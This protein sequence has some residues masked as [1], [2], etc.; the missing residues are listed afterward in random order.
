ML[1]LSLH[2]SLYR[3]KQ[4]SISVNPLKGC[5]MKQKICELHTSYSERSTY[6]AWKIRRDGS[7]S[8]KL[9]HPKL[10]VRDGYESILAGL[11]SLDTRCGFLLDSREG[12]ILAA[13]TLK[14]KESGLHMYSGASCANVQVKM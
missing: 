3:L 14:K 1:S 9:Y 8:V 12:A 4:L 6:W 7:L 10:L 11:I 2:N 5:A 13:E